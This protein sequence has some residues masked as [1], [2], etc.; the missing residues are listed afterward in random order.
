VLAER[1][2]G[3]PDETVRVLGATFRVR[4]EQTLYPRR[5]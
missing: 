3:D 5:V 2:Q 4:A 1:L